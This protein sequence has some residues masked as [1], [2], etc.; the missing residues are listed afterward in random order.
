MREKFR[1]I[2]GLHFR[3]PNLKLF[4]RTTVVTVFT[5]S[6]F[7]LCYLADSN[8]VSSFAAAP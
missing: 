1:L 2:P 5:T 4:A 8:T 6:I 7:L 3:D